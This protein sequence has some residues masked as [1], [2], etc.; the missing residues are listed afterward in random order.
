MQ[1]DIWVRNENINF[2][3]FDE[4][5]VFKSAKL[6]ATQVLNDYSMTNNHILELR[7]HDIETID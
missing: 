7:K 2:K 3:V 1:I 4:K 5:P 6:M